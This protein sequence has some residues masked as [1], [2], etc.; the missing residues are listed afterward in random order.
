MPKTKTKT[1]STHILIELLSNSKYEDAFEY[2]NNVQEV[3]CYEIV[4]DHFLCSSRP[5]LAEKFYL[6]ALDLE[7]KNSRLLSALGSFYFNTRQFQFAEYFHKKALLFNSENPKALCDIGS[8][9]RQKGHFEKAKG[10]YEKIISLGKENE[11]VY[12]NIGILYLYLHDVEKGKHYLEKALELN[13][14]NKT[15]NFYNSFA[16]FKLGDYSKAFECYEGRE[17]FKKPPGEEWDGSENRKIMIMPEQG[18]GDMI[19][20]SR[21]IK[22]AREISKGI[23]VL[24]PKELFRLFSNVDGIDEII[25]FNTE[26]AFDVQDPSE[27]LPSDES[28]ALYD[29]FTRLMSLPRVLNIDVEKESFP[30]DLFKID[31]SSI[32]KWKSVLDFENSKLKIGLCWNSRLEGAQPRSID[33]KEL[34]PILNLDNCD[35]YS[36]Q[37]NDHEQLENYPNIKDFTDEFEDFYDTAAFMENL[38][39]IITVDTSIVHLAGSL[40]KKTY[41]LLN[42]W[43]CWRWSDKPNT[44]WYPEVEVFRQ[45]ELGDWKSVVE[46]VVDKIKGVDQCGV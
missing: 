26:D 10:Y 4:G 6:K 17:W 44:F 46:E 5:D 36:L 15:I 32:E 38:D 41:L 40:R 19:Q 18:L 16:L 42:E 35:F 14:T 27:P 20:F 37:K 31:E 22:K 21:Y 24:C 2:I 12:A 25:E 29:N 13:P 34:E 7:P 43:C 39:L 9:E 11:F 23:I 33:L 1:K 3:E 8:I 30:N 28:N 45:N